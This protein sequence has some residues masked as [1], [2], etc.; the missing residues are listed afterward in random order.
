MPEPE[1]IDY[2]FVFTPAESAGLHD[3]LRDVTASPYGDI[4]TYLDELA[5][6][7]DD[8]RLPARFVEFCELSMLRDF[9]TEP[10]VVIGNAPI[11]RD[12]PVFTTDD[13]VA[14]KRARKKTFVAEGFLGLY[15][16]LTR[17]EMIG[18]LSV[19][20][21]D[22]FHDIY[23]KQSMYDTQSQKTL[24][25][26]RFHRDFTNHFV[27]PDFVNTLTLRDTPENEVYSTFTVTKHAVE[28]LTDR[29]VE[30]LSSPRFY[31]PFDDVTRH[32]ANVRLGRAKDHAV[33]IE[34]QGA[35]VFE[36]RT[37]GL[38]EEAQAALDA[39]IA[40]LHRRKKLRVSR[41]GDSVTFSNHHVIHGREVREIR[42][43]DSLRHRWLL[44]THNVYS[45]QAFEEFFLEDRYGVVN[46]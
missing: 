10:F 29:Q 20:D 34:G 41:P 16:V 43:V 27:C 25:T 42:D 32:S 30:I 22:L 37:E 26:L 23:P 2:D 9:S 3:A 39:F 21:G 33:L 31:T 12:L 40:A 8:T 18:H 11:D 28:E 45:L 46:G 4:T 5:R 6:L 35:K 44:K 7:K 17:T 19:N 15:A 24:G 38:D 36:G 14:E 13:P 1:F